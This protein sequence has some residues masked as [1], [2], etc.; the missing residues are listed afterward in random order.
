MSRTI[1]AG[2]LVLAALVAGC[3]S[4]RPSSPTPTPGPPLT[5]AELKIRLI[6]QLG[7]LWYC[8]PD[9]FP[10]PRDDEADMARQRFA[11]VRADA[12]AFAAVIAHLGIGGEAFT[13]DQ[14]LAI[15]RL[16]KQLK[17]ILLEPAGEGTYRFDYLSM[18]APGAS[19]GR[20][21]VGTID[22]RGTVSIEQ[23]APAGEPICPICL[24]R[25]T[26]ISTPDGEVAIEDVRAGMRLWSLDESGRRFAA[27]VIRVGRTAVPATH[28]V[29]R[30]VLDDGRVVVASPGHP[31]AGGRRFGTIRAG[32]QVDGARVVS[33]T[34][35]AYDGGFTFD[36]LPDGPTGIYVA[37]GVPL[38]STLRQSD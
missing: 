21:S 11:E 23:E 20:R 16:W 25:G 2:L 28:Q 33:A 22:D 38:A 37:D 15:Y 6:E 9:F 34:R 13:D 1:L 24:V 19:E 4:G 29:V 26:R 3:A 30:L 10:V 12:E 17:A 14:R 5:T 35:A 27:T 7:P 8:D 31:L 32:D 18:P 36:L